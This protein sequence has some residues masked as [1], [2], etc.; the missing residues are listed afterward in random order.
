MIPP[1]LP[2]PKPDLIFGYSRTAFNTKQLMAIDLLVDQLGRGYAMPDGKVRLSFLGIEF[3]SQ[4]TGGSHFIATNQLTNAGAIAMEGTLQLARSISSEE[5]LDLD[6]PQF[7]SL[8][9]DHAMAS[10]N[11]HW[12]SKYA[13]SGAFCLHLNLL[14][15]YI[16]D[17]DGLRA[18]NRA[19][20]NILD[21]GV[22]NRLEKIRRYIRAEKY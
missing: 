20:K 8:S 9:I 16:L 17:V 10:L 12:L 5:N 18:V 22:N 3:R 11:V 13:E 15:G 2:K 6:E 19:F 21:Y 7:F 1:P 4:S 14:L